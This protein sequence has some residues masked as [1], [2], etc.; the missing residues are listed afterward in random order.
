[1]TTE[2]AISNAA[3]MEAPWTA[4]TLDNS[5]SAAASRSSQSGP[6]VAAQP[7]SYSAL[8]ALESFRFADSRPS[9]ASCCRTGRSTWI[10]RCEDSQCPHMVELLFGLTF[11]AAS[12]LMIWVALR[13]G[14]KRDE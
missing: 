13:A 9:L 8:S 12:L 11:S 10:A 6:R 5:D 4:G 2:A 14:S 7:M 1:M 3:R